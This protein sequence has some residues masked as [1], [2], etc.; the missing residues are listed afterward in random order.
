MQLNTRPTQVPACSHG[1]FRRLWKAADAACGSGDLIISLIQFDLLLESRDSEEGMGWGR[2]VPRRGGGGP[3]V[4]LRVASMA[5]LD[6]M[7]GRC[8]FVRFVLL[9]VW[10]R[11][12]MV[13]LI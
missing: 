4:P 11:V 2:L 6:R 8:G 12:W 3:Y 13:V 10:E 9:D 1:P 5:V 7:R